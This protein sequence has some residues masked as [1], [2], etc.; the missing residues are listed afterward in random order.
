MDIELTTIGELASRPLSEELIPGLLDDGLIFVVAA[1]GSGKT[2]FA[3]HAGV[4][5][6]S[7]APWRKR[8]VKKGAVIYCIAEGVS[9]FPYRV[10]TAFDRIGMS[11]SRQPFYVLGRSLNLRSD[12]RGRISPDVDALM[13]AVAKKAEEIK[14][15]PRLIVFDTL[16]RFM[17]GGEE[18][19]QRDAGELV[20]GC[21]WLR[22]Q[23]G[24]AIMLVHHTRKAKDL[25]RGSTVFTGAADQVISCHVPKKK[26]LEGPIL[27]T[28]KGDIGKRKDRD[29][30]E[31]WFKF[32]KVPMSRGEMCTM[33]EEDDPTNYYVMQWEEDE[34][35]E[36]KETNIVEDELVMEP[37]E[38]PED[39]DMI[40]GNGVPSDTVERIKALLLSK[41]SMG[42]R[43]LMR[44]TGKAQK[45]VYKALDAMVEEGVVKQSEE[46]KKW[47]L[48]RPGPHNPFDGGE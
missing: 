22:Q 16:N 35:G 44:E 29:P 6:A 2:F 1:E 26:L 17:P 5:V 30:V 48:R 10:T 19:N 13:V 14:E 20:H 31:Q 21:E 36:I 28:T 46:T 43:E 47:K 3:I 7:G 41:G 38:A 33:G 25:A 24:C 18:N 23:L 11:A 42:V 34:Y 12:E 39:A 4:H 8:P 40:A 32:L 45:T 27:W 37:V 15:D 9:F